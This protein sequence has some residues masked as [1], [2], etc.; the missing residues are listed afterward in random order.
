MATLDP[1]LIDN[2]IRAVLLNTD[3][4]T[5]V[6][7]GETVSADAVILVEDRMYPLRDDLTPPGWPYIVWTGE[8]GYTRYASEISLAR[9][10]FSIRMVM[11]EDLLPKNVDL[12]DFTKAGFIAI[13]AAFDN[14]AYLKACGGIVHGCEVVKPF[15]RLYGEPGRRI[16]EMG[17]VARI[18][19]T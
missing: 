15:I 19:S 14:P 8:N 2:W 10:E 18:D 7:D 12:E 6:I 16:S 13:S 9:G 11:R 5:T 1:F 3:C 17:V 4:A